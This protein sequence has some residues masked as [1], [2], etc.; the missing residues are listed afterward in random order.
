MDQ[1]LIPGVEA[2]VVRAVRPLL[3]AVFAEWEHDDL[4][5]TRQLVERGVDARWR[6]DGVDQAHADQHRAL[7]TRGEVDDIVVPSSTP[8]LCFVLALGLPVP[9]RPAGQP[10]SHGAIEITPGRHAGQDRSYLRVQAS[11]HDRLQ[12]AL[13]AAGDDQRA[14]V[15]VLA[16]RQ[17]LCG[18]VTRQVHPQ[19]VAGF[20][21]IVANARIVLQGTRT[22]LVVELLGFVDRQVVGIDVQ[23]QPTLGG[24]IGDPALLQRV[25]AGP[26]DDQHG[27]ELLALLWAGELAADLGTTDVVHG[28]LK[29][30]DVRFAAVGGVELGVRGHGRQILE[31]A[32]P[33][34]VEVVWARQGGLSLRRRNEGAPRAVTL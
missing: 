33:E 23:R 13:A 6:T 17:V 15:P 3:V 25:D 12:A 31:L 27:G 4:L 8:H 20:T 10:A 11:R 29:V 24:P 34:R 14:T 19:E 28:D 30:I 2:G 5:G 1:G 16:F 7:H 26:L 9:H 21:V 22:L 18:A 32:F